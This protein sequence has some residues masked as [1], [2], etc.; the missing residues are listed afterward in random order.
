MHPNIVAVFDSG[1]DGPHHDIA[2]AFVAGKS[3]ATLLQELPAGGTLP[4]REAVQIVRKLAEAL[5]YAHRQGVVHRDVKPGNVMLRDDGE[6]LLMDF[7]LAAR[8]D[9]TEKLSVAGQFM[10]TPEFTA[11]EQWRGEASA[12]SDQY[13]LGCLLFEL[14]TGRVPFRGSSSEHYLL[15]HTQ[16][17]APSPRALRPDLPRDLETIC[18]KCLENEP[19]RRYASCQ[20]LADNLRRWLEG[21]PVTARRAGPLERLGRWMWRKPAVAALLVSLPLM[22]SLLLG[23][24]VSITFALRASDSAT[25]ARGQAERADHEAE[26]VRRLATAEEKARKK[27]EENEE[28]ARAEGRRADREAKA[29]K[30]A[31]RQADVARHGF[32]M[33]AALHA[34]Q[35]HDLVAAEALPL[36]EDVPP[37]FQQTWEYR[38]LRQLCR[39][40]AMTLKGHTREVTSV[41]YCPDGKRIL[42]A[43][44]DGTL[45]VWDA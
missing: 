21:E 5:A 27:A 13:S 17:T 16:M 32:Q 44:Q 3:L 19:T 30:K 26:E 4:L 45:K 18:L 35:Q 41:A 28:T 6:P 25:E 33:A 12:A 1:Q 8:S 22:A 34:R 9:E 20:E 37:A 31:E 7:G 15:L 14:L 39:R 11:P 2:T 29:A 24:V 38:H 36:L 10:G 40:K 42:S 23:S 43:S